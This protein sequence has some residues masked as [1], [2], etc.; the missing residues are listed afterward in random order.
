MAFWEVFKMA[1]DLCKTI[2]AE[3]KGEDCIISKN[4][5]IFQHCRAIGGEERNNECKIS[6]ERLRQLLEK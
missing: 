2:K 1:P 4:N 5:E 3:S 6:Q